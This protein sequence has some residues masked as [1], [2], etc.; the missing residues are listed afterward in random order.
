MIPRRLPPP[1][2]PGN[3]IGVLAPAGR[4]NEPERFYAGITLLEEM[5]Y[6]I[7]YPGNLWPGIDHL[8]DSD[9]NRARECNQLFADPSIRALIALRGGFGCLRMLEYLDIESI[10]RHPKWLVGFSDI[11]LLQNHLYMQTGLLSLHGPVLT[12]LAGTTDNARLR[13]S[14]CLSGFWHEPISLVNDLTVLRGGKT[15][16]A[17]L[18]GGN[19]ASLVSLLGTHY[20]FSWE[21]KIL[22]LEDINEPLYRIDR[23]LTQLSLAGKFSNLAGLLLGDFSGIHPP[24]DHR[25]VQYLQAVWDRTLEICRDGRFPVWAKIPTGHRANNQT[26]PFGAL[27]IMDEQTSCLRFMADHGVPAAAGFDLNADP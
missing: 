23:M 22:F 7:R 8:A 4:L 15:T 16:P 1:A 26:L 24:D 3:T 11:S 5:G 6:Q 9:E 25:Q 27:T 19:L 17:P 13:L 18:L 2:L 10:A 20:D 21:G 12:S 14:R